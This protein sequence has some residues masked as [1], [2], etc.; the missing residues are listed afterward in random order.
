MVYIDQMDIPFSRMI[1]NHMMADTTEE[2]LE[3]AT[4]IGVAHKWLQDKGTHREHFDVCLSMKGK[5]LSLGAI[6]VGW[7]EI[8]ELMKHKKTILK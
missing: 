4:K 6:E 2:L 7:R 3:M 1:M 8:Y 5:A